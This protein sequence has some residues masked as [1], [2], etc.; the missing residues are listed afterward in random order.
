[1][2]S[3]HTSTPWTYIEVKKTKVKV[4]RRIN[5]HTVNSQYLPNG[6]AYEVQAWYTDGARRPAS[7]ASAV[8]SKVKGRKV[9]WRVWQVLADKSRTKRPRN[10]KIGRKVAHL[11][12]NNVHQF[13]DQRQRSRSSGRHNVETGSASYLPNG[14][15]YELQT[16]CTDGR[17]RPLSPKGKIAMS[18]GASDMCWP[19]SLERKVPETSKL[20]SRLQTPRA[21][22]RS[23]F[24]VKRAKVK[25]DYCRD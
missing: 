8:T 20:V 25:L 6:K 13:Q 3:Y 23:S 18:H 1:M 16:W 5:A 21:I 4:T 9:M 2:E 24:K 19:I 22:M 17:W 11:T 12:G 15:A 7:A 10:T 14:K